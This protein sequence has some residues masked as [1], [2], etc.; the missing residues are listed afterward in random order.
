MENFM[1][2]AVKKLATIKVDKPQEK[3]ELEEVAAMTAVG[4][5]VAF[6]KIIQFLGEMVKWIEPKL[7]KF[8]GHGGEEGE[9]KVGNAI[10]AFGDKVYIKYQI[11]LNDNYINKIYNKIVFKINYINE[12]LE[13]CINDLVN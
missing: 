10:L 8:I 3:E 4:V 11:F 13:K 2:T 7:K 5:A 6:P 1:D 9:A 12:T